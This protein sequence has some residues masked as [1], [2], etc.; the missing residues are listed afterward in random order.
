[1][2]IT[3]KTTVP[4]PVKVQYC[5]INEI[6]SFRR[7]FDVYAD[8]RMK[9]GKAFKDFYA[10]PGSIEFTEKSGTRAAGI[11]YQAQVKLYFPGV[12][13]ITEARLLQLNKGKVILK[14]FFSNGDIRI[15]GHPEAPVRLSTETLQNNTKAGIAISGD[16]QSPEKTRFLV[17]TESIL[18]P[19]EL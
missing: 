9:E 3:K 12:D 13:D 18:P 10:A 4:L 17:P 7:Y 8:P 1:M 15:V 16:V 2:A 5:F 11:F 14:L 19:P 6:L